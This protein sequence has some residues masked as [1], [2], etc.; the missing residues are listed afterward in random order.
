MDNWWIDL[1]LGDY[2]GVDCVDDEVVRSPDGDEWA[3]DLDPHWKTSWAWPFP[4]VGLRPRG[5]RRLYAFRARLLDEPLR[6][7]ILRATEQVIQMGGDGGYRP[8][9]VV[10]SNGCPDFFREVAQDG[11]RDG[12]RLSARPGTR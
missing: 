3:E 9:R 7:A 6:A 11:V 5:R 1:F 2:L 4:R 10:R 8:M 12:G